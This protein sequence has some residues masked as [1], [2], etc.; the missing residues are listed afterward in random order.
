MPRE[1]RLRMVDLDG[2][3]ILQSYEDCP[4]CGGKFDCLDCLEKARH[5]KLWLMQRW[6]GME[7]LPVLFI[8][9]TKQEYFELEIRKYAGPGI[10]I[11]STELCEDCVANRGFYQTYLQD[12]LTKATEALASFRT[13]PLISYAQK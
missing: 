10:R 7:P 2:L 3:P 6:K 13:L 11:Q 4:K 9:A 5:P 8:S 1:V 12:G